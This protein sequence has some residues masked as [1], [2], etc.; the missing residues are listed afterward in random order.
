MYYRIAIVSHPT[1]TPDDVAWKAYESLACAGHAV[2]IV[3]PVLYPDVLTSD[4]NLN[5]SAFEAFRSFFKPDYVSLGGESAEELLSAC[6]RSGAAGMPNPAKRFLV[7]GYLG[8]NNFGDEFVFSLIRHAITRRWPEAVVTAIGQDPAATFVR[9]GATSIEPDMKFQMDILLNGAAALVFM[10]GIVF[11]TP[12]FD[13]TA[14]MPELFLNPYS[15]IPGQVSCVQL[16]WMRGVPSAF[17]GIGAGP[18]SNPDAHALLRLASLCQPVFAARDAETA[19]LLAAAGVESNLIHQTADI[20]FSV[21]QQRALYANRTTPA[22]K[23]HPRIVVS[24]RDFSSVDEEFPTRVAT[25]LDDAIERYQ[26][27]ITFLDLAPEDRE[28]H[29]RTATA[30]RYTEVVEFQAAVSDDDTLAALG[31]AHVILATRLHASIIGNAFGVPSVGFDYSEKVRSHYRL[32]GQES[33]LCSLD[34]SAS[35]VSDALHAAFERHEEL[36]SQLTSRADSLAANSACNFDILARLVERSA[37]RPQPHRIYARRVSR[38]AEVLARRERELA[39]IRAALATAEERAKTAE[40]ACEE[41][42]TSTAWKV[43]R[44]ITAPARAIKDMLS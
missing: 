32:M 44:A 20:A 24:L 2:E 1:Y 25:A 28:I 3:D 5:E 10:A 9:H 21:A 42:R 30:M 17:L 14:G 11:D 19:Q 4:G 41:L 29:E 35:C 36:S 38:E 33:L 43:G 12:F 39:E 13:W 34:A 31:G 6:R 26:A 37:A 8:K 7:F 15:E 16:A 40:S 23:D 18:L 22:A 27:L